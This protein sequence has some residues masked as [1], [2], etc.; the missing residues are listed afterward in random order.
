MLK[1]ILMMIIEVNK[2]WLSYC[3]ENVPQVPRIHRHLQNELA[4]RS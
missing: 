3:L 4:G 1:A 2:N